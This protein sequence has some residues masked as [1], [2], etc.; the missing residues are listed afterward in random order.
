M[1]SKSQLCNFTLAF[2]HFSKNWCDYF[3]CVRQI[4]WEG[5]KLSCLDNAFRTPLHWAAVMDS[6]T[7]PQIVTLLLNKGCDWTCSDSNG[8]TPLHYA[9]QKNNAVSIHCIR[10]HS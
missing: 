9:A 5:C 2:H 6:P 10:T 8:A 4:C 3:C 1:F 7:A